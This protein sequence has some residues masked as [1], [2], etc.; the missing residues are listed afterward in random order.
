MSGEELANGKPWR[1]KI[2]KPMLLLEQ[3]AKLDSVYLAALAP[4]TVIVRLKNPLPRPQP[5]PPPASTSASSPATTAPPESLSPVEVAQAQQAIQPE[6][7][8]LKIKVAPTPLTDPLLQSAL[9]GFVFFPVD[10]EDEAN[11]TKRPDRKLVVK[12]PDGTATT[13]S[14]D[15]NSLFELLKGQFTVLTEADARKYVRT[16]LLL[17]EAKHPQFQFGPI[18]QITVTPTPRGGLHATGEAPILS[19]GN[20]PN[21]PLAFVLD[22]TFNKAGTLV[23]GKRTSRTE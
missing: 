9:P 4:E 20:S 5:A 14:P 11:G 15:D 13:L 6:L 2:G 17:V 3:N 16:H 23:G 22:V 19:V 18:D 1:M 10:T 12:K 7:L 21:R 8:K